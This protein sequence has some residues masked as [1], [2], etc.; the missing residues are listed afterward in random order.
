MQV[1][2]EKYWNVRTHDAANIDS[3]YVVEPQQSLE[4]MQVLL[5]MDLI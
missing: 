3:F 2:S 4:S 5:Q 1:D